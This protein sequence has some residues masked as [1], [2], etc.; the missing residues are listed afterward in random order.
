LEIERKFLVG[1]TA[2]DL[3]QAS[4][5]TLRQGYLIVAESGEVR[6][7]DA[8]GHC[9]LTVKTGAGLVRGEHEI[10]LTPEQFAA[11]WPATERRRV[12]KQ[13]YRVAAGEYV[14]E[15]DVYAGTLKGLV[16]VEV[17]FPTVE[18]AHLFAV[19]AW[20][21][22]EVTGVSGFSNAELALHG[23]PDGGDSA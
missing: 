2:P 14:C 16:T 12:E 13:R 21:G 15:L 7:R 11:L 17:E 10:E 23:A 6:V 22:S 4:S 1:D 18:Q 19:P 8:G 9:T 20:F 5:V 3:D